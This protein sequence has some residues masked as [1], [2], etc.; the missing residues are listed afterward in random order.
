MGGDMSDKRPDGKRWDERTV[1]QLKKLWAHGL[2]AGQIAFRL[3][4]TRNAVIGKVHRLG[5]P[6]RLVLVRKPEDPNRIRRRKPV[7]HPKG[8]V[9]LPFVHSTE[10]TRKA[11]IAP[12]EP[13]KVE[14]SYP[15]HIDNRDML[16]QCAWPLWGE[17]AAYSGLMC[18]G[19]PIAQGEQSYCVGCARMS[20]GRYQSRRD[21]A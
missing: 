21:A 8:I 16:K 7:A 3:G 10:R 19:N 12:G 1:E 14:S 4:S 20:A 9:S 17:G 5:L 11:P 13:I 2:T 18:C 15:V 6:G